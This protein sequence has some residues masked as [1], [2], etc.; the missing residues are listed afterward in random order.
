[1]LRDIAF[2]AKV[3]KIRVGQRVRWRWADGKYVAHNIHSVGSPRF[4]GATARTAG[5]WT[6]RFA[7]KG[8]YR[9]TCTLHPGMNG[10]VVVR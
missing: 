2:H 8:T 9:Y 5:T 6:V 3:T 10:T 1:M 4:A 7:R